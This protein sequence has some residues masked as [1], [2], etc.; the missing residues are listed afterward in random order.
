MLKNGSPIG[1]LLAG[2]GWLALSGILGLALLIGLVHGTPLPPWVRQIHVHAALVGGVTQFILGGFL[3]LLAPP[4]H[5]DQPQQHSHVLPFL[6]INVGTFGMLMGFGFR[7]NLAVAAAGVIVLGA[8]AHITWRIWTHAHRCSPSP[9]RWYFTAAFLALLAGLACGEGLVLTPA[10]QSFGS[11]RLAHLHLGLLG[12]IIPIGIGASLNILPT[13]L[14]TTAAALRFTRSALILIPLGVVLLLGG[15]LSSSVRIEMAAG[16]LLF[17]GVALYAVSLFQTWTASDHEGNAASDH[18]L[19]GTFF[20]L[21][22]IILG[23]LLGMNNLSSPPTMP[24]GT[25]HLIAY[26][27]IAFLGFVLQT[28]MGSLSH[29]LPTTLATHRIHRDKNRAPYLGQ[30]TTIMNRWRAIQIGG[31]SLGTMGLGVLATLAWNVPLTSIPIQAATWTCFA[32]LL[33]SLLLFSV[34]LAMAV[35]QAPDGSARTPVP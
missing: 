7:Y 34:K 33:S 25:L 35:G 9:D 6:T 20:L 18:L 3:A 23:V 30:L 15:F 12:F 19:I 26:T 31:L 8:V 28:I 11:V 24:Y 27:H 1:L 13:I 16:G 10:Q 21:L 5:A 29:I 17:A 32:L 2:F 14:N 22:T 4:P